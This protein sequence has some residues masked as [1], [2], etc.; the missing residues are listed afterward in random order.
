VWNETVVAWFEAVFRP[1]PG[2]LRRASV[3]ITGLW[4]GI[5]TRDYAPRS[6][7]FDPSLAHVGLCWTDGNET[8][9][10]F[11]PVLC[12][13]TVNIICLY[14]FRTPCAHHQ[15]V[16]IV[17]YDIWYHHTCRWPSGAQVERGLHFYYTASGVLSQ[18]AHRTAT[19][20]C[21]DTRCCIIQFDLLM[22]STTVL[23]TC[24]GI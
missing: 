19:C 3:V 12:L 16:K 22:M 15:Q 6:A 23:E 2:G 24:R 5:L 8:G 4:A 21:D 18:P 14:M 13:S 11:S 10:S 17:L 7:G 1:L 20:R 9:F